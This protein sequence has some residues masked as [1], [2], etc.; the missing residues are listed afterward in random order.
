M[1]ARG[2]EATVER[3]TIEPETAILDGRTRRLLMALR[4]AVIIILGALEDY[5]CVE[6]SIVPRRKR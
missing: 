1:W 3:L 6:R 4:Q 2:R 5:L